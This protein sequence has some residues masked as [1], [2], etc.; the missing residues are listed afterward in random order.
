MKRARGRN[1]SFLVLRILGYPQHRR[2]QTITP[3][4]PPT[5]IPN[6]PPKPS[7]RSLIYPIPTPRPHDRYHDLL[8]QLSNFDPNHRHKHQ[9]WGIQHCGY[10]NTTH[11]LYICP[12]QASRRRKKEMSSDI[13]SK[14]DCHCAEQKPSSFSTSELIIFRMIPASPLAFW[15]LPL[16]RRFPALFLIQLATQNGGRG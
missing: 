5:D 1:V 10:M 15:F 8:C 11:T 7:L 14:K 13:C 6:H 16:V 3:Y 2:H 12:E 9:I 4:D